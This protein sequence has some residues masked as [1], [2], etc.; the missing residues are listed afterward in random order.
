MEA[1]PIIFE[2]LIYGTFNEQKNVR[3]DFGKFVDYSNKNHIKVNIGAMEYYVSSMFAYVYKNNRDENEIIDIRKEKYKLVIQACTNVFINQ[4]IRES[5]LSLFSRSQNVYFAFNRL[6][7]LYKCKKSKLGCNSDMYLNPISENSAN[8]LSII[9]E[10]T[11]YLFTLHDLKKIINQS[12]LNHDELYSDPLPIKNPY[13]NL[14]FSKSILY[15]IYFFI[16]KSSYLVPTSFEFYFQCDFSLRQLL[17]NY[18]PY[19][20][21]MSIK[22]CVKNE[23]SYQNHI[24]YIHNMIENYNL[25]HIDNQILI[26]EDFPHHVLINTFRLY[27]PYYLKSVFSLSISEKNE[28]KF[29]I[30]AMLYNFQQKN[31]SFGRKYFKREYDYRIKKK[32]LK[33][34]FHMQSTSFESPLVLYNSYKNCHKS[35]ENNYAP[36]VNSYLDYNSK[37]KQNTHIRFTENMVGLFNSTYDTDVDQDESQE[38]GSVS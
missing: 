26:D 35:V 5:F 18:E 31:S 15:K 29:L 37:T 34:Q 2:K 36:F 33:R 25:L 38:M 13:N 23:D 30:H 22:A 27:I 17:N 8:V 1:F 28:Y 32:S 19:L 12:L 11:K 24:E 16:K 20:R 14:P 10:N 21:N 9:H 6:A 3:E 7:Y 4:E